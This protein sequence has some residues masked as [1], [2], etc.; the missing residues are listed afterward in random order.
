[1]FGYKSSIFCNKIMN[2]N[3]CHKIFMNKKKKIDPQ[4]QIRGADTPAE[5]I[6]FGWNVVYGFAVAQFGI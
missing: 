5:N 6:C 2:G 4:F 1:M 3:I